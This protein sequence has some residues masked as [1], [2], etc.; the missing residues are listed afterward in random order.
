MMFLINNTSIRHLIILIYMLIATNNYSERTTTTFDNH[1]TRSEDSIIGRAGNSGGT[2][3]PISQKE[4]GFA[5]SFF[6]F[7]VFT[8]LNRK[9]FL[10]LLQKLFVLLR[11]YQFLWH[12]HDFLFWN[13]ITTLFL[14]TY[15]HHQNHFIA[16]LRVFDSIYSLFSQK[17]FSKN[18]K[19]P[20][21]T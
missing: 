10:K 11:L 4:F 7:E 15:P 2:R 9:K 21:N 19:V 20:R 14:W 18:L 3:E 6:D 8:E 16:Q 17:F 1:P 12:T 13:T 5:E